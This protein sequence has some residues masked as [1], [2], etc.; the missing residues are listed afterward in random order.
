MKQTEYLYLTEPR[1]HQREAVNVSLNWLEENN[2][3]AYY[4]EQGTGKSKTL[5]DVASHLFR[6]DRIDAAML[7]APNG[8]HEQWANEQLPEHSPLPYSTYEWEGMPKSEIKLNRLRQFCWSTD[9][10]MLRWFCV[11]I[12]AFSVDSGMKVFQSFVKRNRVAIIVDEC[13]T[14]KNTGAKCTINVG[15]GLS[16]LMMNGKYVT[17]VNPYSAY[18]FV[19]T[20]TMVTNNPFDQYSYGEFLCPGI[21]GMNEYRFRARYGMITRMKYGKKPNGKDNMVR[22]QM[23][24]D[25]IARIHRQIADGFRIE[26]IAY[27]NFTS[28][29]VVLW[30]KSHPD[31]SV[32]YKNL[33]ELKEKIKPWSFICKKSECLDLPEKQHLITNYE[34]SKEQK[35]VYNDLVRDFYAQ[36]GDEE[37]EVTIKLALMTRL[38]QVT[39]GFFPYY[40]DGSAKAMPIK[41]NGKFKALERCIEETDE[42]PLIVVARFTAE[43]EMIM[44]EFG[45]EGLYGKTKDRNAVRERFQSNEIDILAVNPDVGCM[46]Y[47]FQNSCNMFIY[48][49]DFSLLKREQMEDRIHRDGQRSDHVI[50]RDLIAKGTVDERIYEVLRLKKDLLDFMRD[51]K[52]VGEFVGGRK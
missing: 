15:H 3:F 26:D 39:G 11:N 35:E 10:R 14:I 40:D 45:A 49:N 32:P 51:V 22:K 9:R 21:W 50:Y 44:E 28:T 19:L 24:K 2:F 52:N 16:E 30:M 6:T 23:S 13:T 41:G 48:S 33:G 47:N 37:I 43:I 38:S 29:D 12:E 1:N 42:R 20:G 7:I 27:K 17:K 36:Y 18:R 4:M 31:V 34:M 25:M 8:V 5:I 46:G